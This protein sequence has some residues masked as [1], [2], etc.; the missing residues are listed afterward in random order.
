MT[1]EFIS[2]FIGLLPTY[3]QERRKQNAYSL[4]ALLYRSLEILD[5]PDLKVY[6]VLDQIDLPRDIAGLDGERLFIPEE[7][8][9]NLYQLGYNGFMDV[10]AQARNIKTQSDFNVL[11]PNSGGSMHAWQA[12]EIYS[13]RSLEIISC[14]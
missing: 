9:Q 12:I 8:I 13:I 1:R 4:Y 5:H 6:T 7:T 2:T 11:N 10:L 14:K 3:Q